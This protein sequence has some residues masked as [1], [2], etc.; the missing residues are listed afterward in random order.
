MGKT[1][2]A[3]TRYL[4]FIVNMISSY[5]KHFCAGRRVRRDKT[6]LGSA[7]LFSPLQHVILDAECKVEEVPTTNRHS[8]KKKYTNLEQ[9]E[10]LYCISILKGS[11]QNFWT[12]LW[13]TCKAMQKYSCAPRVEVTN[14]LVGSD[15]KT[16]LGPVTS[17]PVRSGSHLL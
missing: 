14:P 4:A 17:R 5:D 11:P 9:E 3:T 1:S 16:E 15:P 6:G 12:L 10:F 13:K 2:L 8:E 7:F